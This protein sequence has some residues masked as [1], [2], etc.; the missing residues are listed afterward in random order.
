MDGIDFSSVPEGKNVKWADLARAIHDKQQ[1]RK[2]FLS[3]SPQCVMPDHNLGEAIKAGLFDYLFV[4]FFY[5]NPSCQYNNG[6]PSNLIGTYLDWASVDPKTTEVFLGIPAS[7]KATGSGYIEPEV[8]KNVVL[9]ELKQAPNYGGIMLLNRYF[10][11]ITGYSDQIKDSVPKGCDDEYDHSHQS[12]KTKFH[13]L[14][15]QY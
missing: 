13:S 1:D 4:G 9:P 15:R 7:A 10:D 11:K 6:D 14:L 5:P 12:A 2:F 8:L 3:A